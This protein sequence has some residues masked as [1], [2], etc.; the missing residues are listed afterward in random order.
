MNQKGNLKTVQFNYLSLQMSEL[1][2]REEKCLARIMRPVHFWLRV[3]ECLRLGSWFYCITPPKLPSILIS[4]GSIDV[5]LVTACESQGEDLGVLPSHLETNE[6]LHNSWALVVAIQ[7]LCLCQSA[8]H[9]VH[10]PVSKWP[11]WMLES[12]AS[13]GVPFPEQRTLACR[14]LVLCLM[15]SPIKYE[16]PSENTWSENQ[17]PGP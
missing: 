7:V 9:V 11:P 4:V 10:L 12:E 2:P 15:L 16:I 14:K 17:S 1:R 13:V 6:N 3:G 8:A 5:C